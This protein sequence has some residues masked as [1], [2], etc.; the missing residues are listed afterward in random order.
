VAPPLAHK[1]LFRRQDRLRLGL[2]ERVRGNPAEEEQDAAG[3][4]DGGGGGSQGVATAGSGACLLAG[5]GAG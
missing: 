1:S 5:L 2:A 3:G 4:G